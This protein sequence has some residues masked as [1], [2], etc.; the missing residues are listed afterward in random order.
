MFI[1]PSV[2]FLIPADQKKIA[3]GSIEW[4]VQNAAKCL[5]HQNMWE[6]WDEI[7]QVY[8]ADPEKSVGTIGCPFFISQ[9]ARYG[10]TERKVEKQILGFFVQNYDEEAGIRHKFK[11]FTGQDFC[12]VAEE[13]GWIA[14]HL[15]LK[16]NQN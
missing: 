7:N 14:I 16:S 9:I 4:E 1:A 11:E 3:C 8:S 10:F 5:A 13:R 6:R 2:I 12:D 15:K